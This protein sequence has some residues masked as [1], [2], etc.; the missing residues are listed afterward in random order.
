MKACVAGSAIG[1]QV[2]KSV[3]YTG[4]NWVFQG[5]PFPSF[6]RRKHLLSHHFQLIAAQR[7]YQQPIVTETIFDASPS[8]YI[9]NAGTE[10]LCKDLANA[11]QSVIL[12]KIRPNSAN[13]PYGKVS[14][15]NEISP[16]CRCPACS[17]VNIA[18][19]QAA[20]N[21]GRI[22]GAEYA[23]LANYQIVSRPGP[24]SPI[25]SSPGLNAATPCS[26]IS[27]PGLAGLANQIISSGLTAP[28]QSSG[29]AANNGLYAQG[30]SPI[31]SSPGLV[32]SNN[33]VSLPGNVANNRYSDLIA[34]LNGLQSSSC[35]CNRNPRLV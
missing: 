19:P 11:I 32:N 10:V 24:G 16:V 27:N 34:L 18:N 31:V 23:A 20:Q 7:L 14:G 25:I 33:V 28:L 17:S 9:G 30:F 6:I 29:I 22:L 35:G 21:H 5:I 3:N 15:L 13:G 26:I 4:G 12:S 8:P 2:K 1:S